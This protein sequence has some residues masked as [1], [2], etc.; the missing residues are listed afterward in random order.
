MNSKITALAAYLSC[1]AQEIH[2]QHGVYIHHGRQYLVLTD[3]E[4]DQA[5]RDDIEQSLFAFNADFIAANARVD[6]GPS[7]VRALREV[8]S[9][10]CEESNPLILAIIADLEGFVAKACSL[11]GRGHFV[12]HYDGQEHEQDGLYIYRVG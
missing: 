5:A 10:L 8:Q 2:C 7:G 4:A 11:D 1:S 9:K 6:I 3:Q 12:S